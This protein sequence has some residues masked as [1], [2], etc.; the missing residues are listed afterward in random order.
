MIYFRTS[1]RAIDIETRLSSTSR[2][3][4]HGRTSVPRARMYMRNARIPDK[5]DKH[6]AHSLIHLCFLR[7]HFNV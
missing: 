2:H 5:I 7:C 1:Q 4:I 3:T 6:T